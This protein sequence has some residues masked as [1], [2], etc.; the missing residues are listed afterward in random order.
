MRAV[1]WA[2][3]FSSIA[4]SVA[5]HAQREP[6]CRDYPL[7]GATKDVEQTPSGFKI[8]A[9]G[10]AT[11]NFDDV[12]V[13]RDAREEAEL[14][15]KAIISKF[16][17]EGIRSDSEVERTVRESVSMQGEA[18]TATRNEAIKRIKTLRNSSQ[19][20]LRGVQVLGGCYTPGKEVRVTV[21]LKPETIAAAEA[22]AGQVSGSSSRQGTPGAASASQPAPSGL[23]RKDG[24]SD[25]ERLK[26]F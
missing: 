2:V 24:Y 9:T 13:V 11:V 19:A 12:A 17:S 7:K 10:D 23:N 26:K 21:G 25:T 5:S 15:A 3:L 22:I 16:L 4:F 14:E 18:K 6:S 8:V 1:S 20:L